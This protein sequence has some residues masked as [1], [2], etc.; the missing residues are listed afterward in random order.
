MSKKKKSLAKKQRNL[1]EDLF[2]GD[3][4]EFKVLKKHKITSTIYRRWLKDKLFVDEI[5]FRMESGRRQSELIIAMHAPI[6][7]SKL[8]ALSEGPKEEV[9]R[10]ACLDIITLPSGVS[11]PKEEKDVCEGE[12]AAGTSLDPAAASKLLEALSQEKQ[13]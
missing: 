3:M 12:L 6:A 5:K 8:A 11:Q 2:T 7:T 10:K 9:A 1:I 4:N 13:K